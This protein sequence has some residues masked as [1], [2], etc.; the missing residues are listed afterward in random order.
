MTVAQQKIIDG[1]H[2]RVI[3][4]IYKR[5]RAIRW[6]GGQTEWGAITAEINA[7][8]N[9]R[10]VYEKSL[11]GDSNEGKERSRAP[12]SEESKIEGGISGSPA[13]TECEA[14]DTKI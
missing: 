4:L 14:A 11:K 12:Q 2:E 5:R 13:E 10:R 3:T 6:N 9:E 1:F 7:V 8:E